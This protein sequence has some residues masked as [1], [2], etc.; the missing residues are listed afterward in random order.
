[1]WG[2]NGMNKIKYQ[3]LS[4]VETLITL[5]IVGIVILVVS[6]TLVALIKASA[7][8][9][10]RTLSRSE[11]ELLL[12]LLKRY[13]QNSEV[14]EVDVLYLP[15][16][17]RYIEENGDLVVNWFSASVVDENNPTVRGNEIHFRPIGSNEWVCVAYVPG[18]NPDDAGAILRA[19]SPTRASQCFTGSSEYTILNSSDIDVNSLEISY[20]YASGGNINY[21][22]DLDIEPVHWIPGN[23][24]QFRPNFPRQLVVSTS[25][26]TY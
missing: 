10:A 22:I 17:Q 11:S 16:G 24:S 7:I 23:Q 4:L 14:D 13:I 15:P 8:A 25:K 1:M 26:L 21:I 9:Q 19:N 2:L 6:T 3:G 12:E 18:E 20:F 5:V